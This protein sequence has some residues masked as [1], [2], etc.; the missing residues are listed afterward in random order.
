MDSPTDVATHSPWTVD[1]AVR[2]AVLLQAARDALV[3]GACLEAVALAEE[4][5]EENPEEVEALLLV[6][7][8]A[9]RYGHGRVALLALEQAVGLGAQ[10]GA[11]RIAALLALGEVEAA[12]REGDRVLLEGGEDRARAQALRGQ[13]LELL[14][15]WEEADQ[16]FMQAAALR[17]DLY[18][19]SPRPDSHQWQG[20]LQEALGQL[21]AEDQAALI[22]TE[23]VFA[24]VPELAETV[25]RP[26]SSHSTRRFLERG[27]QLVL[28][29]QNL[30]RGA[31]D[32]GEL[33]QRL[34]DALTWEAASLRSSG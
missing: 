1:R 27:P 16:A 5:L 23:L 26:P 12:L 33:R 21:Q 11:L 17:P 6:A 25:N 30:A 13:A 22:G 32:L 9:P 20:L 29:Q 34:A 8:A 7:D 3:A 18:P 14:G 4:V 28:F 24:K 10:S 19:L 2:V 31:A 15:R